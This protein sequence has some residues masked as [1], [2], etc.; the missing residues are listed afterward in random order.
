MFVAKRL[1]RLS[2]GLKLRLEDYHLYIKL[3]RRFDR[4]QRFFVTHLSI[5]RPYFLRLLKSFNLGVVW[6]TTYLSFRVSILI[7]LFILVLSRLRL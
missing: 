7:F 1:I 6:V 3:S 2:F 4:Y 5:S